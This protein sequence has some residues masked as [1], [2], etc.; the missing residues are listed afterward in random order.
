MNN[1]FKP[2]LVAFLTLQMIG[3]PYISDAVAKGPQDSIG[4]MDYVADEILVK[5]R[6]GVSPK[7]KDQIE[8]KSR[9]QRIESLASFQITR[10]KVPKD[11][12]HSKIKE[13][14]RQKE[15]LYAE[16]NFIKRF[17]AQP[18][19]PQFKQ[20]WGLHNTGQKIS[21]IFGAPD[22]DIDALQGWARSRGSTNVKIAVVDTGIQ[23]SHPDL[24]KNIWSND[25]EIPNNDIDDD[26]NGYV[27]DTH[28]WDFFY[29]D[30]TTY[31]GVEDFHGTHVAGIIGA[32]ANNSLG[33]SGINWST[34]IM[35][36]KFIGDGGFG[37]VYGEIKALDYAAANGAKIINASYGSYDYSKAEFEAIQKLR[38]KGILFV[39]AV[40]NSADNNDASPAYP[41]NYGLSNI[42]SV[43]ASN[44]K[45]NRASFTNSGANSV[46]IF[47]PGANI[48]STYPSDKYAYLTG[49]SMAAPF[50]TGAA[51]LISS[52]N[53]NSYNRTKSLLLRSKDKN[54]SFSNYSQSGGRVNVFD[55]LRNKKPAIVSPSASQSLKRGTYYSFWWD[56]YGVKHLPYK[57]WLEKNVSAPYFE[58]FELRIP[59]GISYR[60]FATWTRT[61]AQKFRGNYSFASGKIGDGKSSAF[62]VRR[63]IPRQSYISFS[64][65]VSSEPETYYSSGDSLSFQ[66]D[67]MTVLRRSGSTGWRTKRFLIKK[68][69]HTFRW[70]YA[71]D[72][73]L[74]FGQDK[75]WIDNIRFS[76][77]P[78]RTKTVK[79]GVASKGSNYYKWQIPSALP[80]G[81]YKLCL[82]GFSGAKTTLADSMPI[83]IK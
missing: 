20:Q 74:E 59:R 24:K 52:L 27:D 62:A 78:S 54:T 8:T 29:E 12:V 4:K 83:K 44:N 60:G 65:K 45:D 41:A 32:S 46:D 73:S 72:Y 58:N 19:D 16:P 35:P 31:D 43:G 53:G 71:K 37:T 69:W 30:N 61:T 21:G 23:W 67:G 11:Q 34:S 28:G 77:R 75:A 14:E 66:I 51:G 50:V 33:I 26:L 13:L 38:S 70:I 79:I 3:F 49:T 68:G 1:V 10:L 18:N 2:I 56:T 15:V 40:G 5:Y 6:S 47:A 57:L 25:L 81:N 9:A 55:S 36:V 22:A 82:Q 7:T 39:A 80:A 42:I 64:Y 17:Y 63:Y 76:I 48:I